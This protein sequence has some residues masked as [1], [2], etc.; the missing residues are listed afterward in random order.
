MPHLDDIE[1][2]NSDAPSVRGTAYDLVYNGNELGSGSIRVHQPELQRRVLKALGLSDEEIEDKFGFLLSALSAGA[3]P[4]GGIAL[5]MD[6]IAQRFSQ[7][8]SLRDV[9]AFPKT[10]AARALYEGAPAL[11]G[12]AELSE[13]GI[14]VL[15][16]SDR[17][18]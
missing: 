5:G 2:L 18:D 12:N 6:R 1:L 13:L 8:E 17:E 9:I 15:K 14:K 10:T 16:G 7:S 11:V 3:P 4:H